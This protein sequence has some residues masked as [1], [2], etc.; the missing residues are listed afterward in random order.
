MLSAQG[1]DWKT[2]T[3][4]MAVVAG[5]AVQLSD[6]ARQRPVVGVALDD[7]S[8]VLEAARH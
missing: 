1:S 5:T 2:A 7:G 3:I 4:K 8:S 6:M